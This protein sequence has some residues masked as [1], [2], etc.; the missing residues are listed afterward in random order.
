MA[1]DSSG[2]IYALSSD[3]IRKYDDAGSLVVAWYAPIAL[4]SLSMD[5]YDHLLALADSNEYT[6]VFSDGGALLG[7]FTGPY[8]NFYPGQLGADVGPD[9]KYY[10]GYPYGPVNEGDWFVEMCL[11]A[12]S[13]T[14][15][16]PTSLGKIKAMYQ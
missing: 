2:Y 14:N 7:S 5:S 10:V 16:V 1:V 3:R 13:P 15:V 4:D 11:L 8:E 9:G 12:P 6:Y